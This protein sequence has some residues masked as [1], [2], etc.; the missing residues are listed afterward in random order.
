MEIPFSAANWTYAVHETTKSGKHAPKSSTTQALLQRTSC[1]ITPSKIRTLPE[2]HRAM[3]T[4]LDNPSIHMPDESP[5]ITVLEMSHIKA[6]L[7]AS[8]TEIE[9]K[10][11]R[12]CASPVIRCGHISRASRFTSTRKTNTQ[13]LNYGN[14]FMCHYLSTHHLFFLSLQTPPLYVTLFL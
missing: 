7:P 3:H 9:N 14:N 12:R 8:I 4:R 5:E 6:T 2:L 13:A 10:I 1:F 11:T